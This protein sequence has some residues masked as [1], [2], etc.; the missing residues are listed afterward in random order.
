MQFFLSIIQESEDETAVSMDDGLDDDVS[1]GDMNNSMSEV[2]SQGRCMIFYYHPQ[3]LLIVCC[4]LLRG[5][6]RLTSLLLRQLLH[7]KRF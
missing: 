4:P 5:L 7:S 3:I 2:D 6:A 1:D